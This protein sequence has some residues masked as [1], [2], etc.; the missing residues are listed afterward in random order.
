[1]NPK[2]WQGK[3]VFLTGHTG[4]KGGWLS[5]WLQSLGADL[6]GYAL[7]PPTNPSL[8]ERANV[9]EKMTSVIGDIRDLDN[10]RNVMKQFQPEI[11]LHLAAQPLVRHSY[12]NP[13]ETYS[14]NVMGTVNVLEAIRGT[15]SVRSVVVVTTDKCYENQEWVWPYRENEAMG[16][17]DPYSSSKGCAE[18]VTAAYRSSY[19]NPSEYQ[20]HHVGIASARAGNVIGGG[21]WSRDR[22]I[23]DILNAVN[24]GAAVLLRN[25]SAIRPWQHVLEP[26]YG[27][28]VLAENLYS[29]GQKFSEAWNFGPE[30][31]DC[32]SVLEIA[33]KLINI[34]G[35]KSS[36]ALED[37]AGHPHEAGLLK[38]DISKAKNLLGWQPMLSIDLSLKWI[39]DWN[40]FFLDG[41]DLKFITLEQISNYQLLNTDN[42]Q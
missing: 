25:P 1:M 41:S 26:L 7:S 11:V 36:I 21:D 24:A 2:F 9:A 14:T 38:L 35:S 4:F 18:L 3:K 34:S 29:E 30:Q 33:N 37:K 20:H 40:K 32:I 31:A 28:L 5:L 13:I 6:E 17:R 27:Y 22:L 19:F 23:P 10:L 8:F 42:T 12:E 16:G 39:C 15:A